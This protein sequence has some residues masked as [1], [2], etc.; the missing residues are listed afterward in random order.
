MKANGYSYPVLAK[1]TGLAIATIQYAVAREA[2][3][4]AIRPGNPAPRR[5][6]TYWARQ[7]VAR[8]SLPAGE[9]DYLGVVWRIGVNGASQVPR[10]HTGDFCMTGVADAN[11]IT[12]WLDLGLTVRYL[13]VSTTE[14]LGS[15][16][17]ARVVAA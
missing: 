13:K 17:S 1:V 6:A 14:E 9:L 7:R 3:P 5:D 2:Q 4:W 8:C 12:E 16:T 15:V 10:E 11:A